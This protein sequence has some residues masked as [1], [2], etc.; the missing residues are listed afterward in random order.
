LLAEPERKVREDLALPPFGVLALLR[1]PGSDDYAAALR[2]RTGLTVSASD[3]E[4]WLVRAADHPT[5]CD[6]LASTPRP[7][8][9]LRVEVDPT[10]V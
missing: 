7:A 3:S 10:D 9:R 6:A 5:L 2:A 4:R 1:G 8:G